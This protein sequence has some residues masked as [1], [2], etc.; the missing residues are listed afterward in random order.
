MRMGY[1]EPLTLQLP[2]LT[3]IF[4]VPP[5]HESIMSLIG[6]ASDHRILQIHAKEP[7]EPYLTVYSTNS[8]PESAH[9][10]VILP[11]DPMVWNSSVSEM[12]LSISE[13]GDLNFWAPEANHTWRKTGSVKTGRKNISRARCS[14]A[15]KT[16]LVVRQPNGGDEVSIWDSKESQFSSGLEYSEVFNPEDPVIDLD[17]TATPDGQSILAIGFPH[18][19]LLLYQQ[20]MTY[21][22]QE[23]RWGVFDK[24]EVG[25]YVLVHKITSL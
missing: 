14:T 10:A 24:M 12:I 17:W 7:P 3:D 8:L 20:R 11:V 13:E 2:E 18:H 1:I 23:P 16:V 25:R 21:F 6:I 5:N 22:D 9:P 15:K 19:I 4:L